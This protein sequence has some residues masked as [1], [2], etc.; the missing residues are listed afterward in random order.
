MRTLQHS[1]LVV[2]SER[3][4]AAPPLPAPLE[5]RLENRN[6]KPGLTIVGKGP[7]K[8]ECYKDE[9]DLMIAH[10]ARS[11]IYLAGLFFIATGQTIVMQAASLRVRQAKS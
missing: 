6:N 3:I 11:G 1:V 4:R 5:E 2:P 7:S 10:Q 9:I 8:E